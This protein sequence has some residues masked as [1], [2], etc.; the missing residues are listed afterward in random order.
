MSQL[1]FC[2]QWANP[3]HFDIVLQLSEDTK[4]L[5]LQQTSE[6]RTLRPLFNN[7]IK[8]MDPEINKDYCEHTREMA[9]KGTK[10]Q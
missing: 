2:I 7:Q 9:Q 4:K 8:K 3:S 6:E 1:R 5:L 10:D